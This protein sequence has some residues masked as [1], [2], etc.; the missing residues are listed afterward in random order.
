MVSKV[1]GERRDKDKSDAV[2]VDF[3]VAV[4]WKEDKMENYNMGVN[5]EKNKNLA[6]HRQ[7]DAAVVAGDDDWGRYMRGSC[8]RDC[9]EGD[10]Y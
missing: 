10:V 3:V 7:G 4:Y 8:Y 1:K 6:A 2:V 5:K 9:D